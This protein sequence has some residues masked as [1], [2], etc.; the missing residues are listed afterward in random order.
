MALS[1]QQ[2]RDYVRLHLDLEVE[3]LPDQVLDVF[4]REGS[5]RIE[6]AEPR[7]PFYEVSFPLTLNQNESSVAKTA[8]DTSLDQITAINHTPAVAFP[9]LRWIGHDTLNDQLSNRPAALG[10]PY[11]FS[12]WAG[13][14]FFF[15]A[16]DIA[17]TLTV[18]GYRRAADWVSDGAGAVP[19]LPDELHNTVAMWA[20]Q[21]AYAQQED[22]ELS[23]LYE[24]QFLD[25]LN[26]FRRRLVITPHN[27]PLVLNGGAAPEPMTRLVRP[28][29]DWEVH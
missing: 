13:S 10:R 8:I 4:I 22:P 9:P 15:P 19:D 16:A 27:Q 7:W 18:H 6:R 14:V 23:S 29:Y 21:K 24:R 5:R 3:D 12:E 28:R 26:E 25:E 11:Y 17:Y 1:L 2:I 20:I